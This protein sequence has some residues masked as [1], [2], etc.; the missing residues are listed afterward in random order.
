METIRV[1]QLIERLSKLDKHDKVYC[2]GAPV[3]DGPEPVASKGCV[4]IDPKSIAERSK[5][6][7]YVDHYETKIEDLQE[8]ITSIKN[9]IRAALTSIDEDEIY[10]GTFALRKLIK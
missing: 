2:G 5:L 7:E 8:E 1:G 4:D 9:S 10:E 3:A 6:A